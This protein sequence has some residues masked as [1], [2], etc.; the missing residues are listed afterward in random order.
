MQIIAGGLDRPDVHALLEAHLRDMYATS[1]ACSV[2]ALDLEALRRPGVS[3]WTVLDDEGVAVAVG[4][5]SDLAPGEGEVKSMRVDARARGR[6]VGA[7]LLA[8]IVD[9]AHARE[10]ARVR[11]ET[12]SEDFFAPARRLYERA[13]FAETGPFG[14]YTDDPNSTYYVL[15]LN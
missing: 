4:G 2:H 10:L 3:F 6:G 5:L 7:L 9:V 12:G 15:E 13:G 1:P 11:L 8:H 14:S